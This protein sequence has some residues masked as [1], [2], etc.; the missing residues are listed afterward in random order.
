[1]LFKKALP[2]LGS[3]LICSLNISPILNVFGTL[4]LTQSTT[5]PPWEYSTNCWFTGK[6][7]NQTR[8]SLNQEVACSF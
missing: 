7:R 3:C 2:V 5:A 4:N 6:I 8:R 1:M